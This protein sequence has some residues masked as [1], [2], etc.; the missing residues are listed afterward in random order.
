MNNKIT[1][2]NNIHMITQDMV[3][4]LTTGE[5]PSTLANTPFIIMREM[6]SFKFTG[7]VGWQYSIMIGPKLTESLVIS[8]RAALSIIE[9]NDMYEA[10]RNNYGNI[11]EISSGLPFFRKFATAKKKRKV[12]GS[13][14]QTAAFAS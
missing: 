9:N 11:W 2:N 10:F 1:L 7:E 14:N 13:F 6:V 5:L 12:L 3:R 4:Q 8:R